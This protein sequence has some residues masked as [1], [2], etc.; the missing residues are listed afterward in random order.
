MAQR[1]DVLVSQI[2][3]LC[4]AAP[5]KPSAKG[6]D[7]GSA[8]SELHP[9]TDAAKITCR[10]EVQAEQHTDPSNQQVPGDAKPPSDASSNAVKSWYQVGAPYLEDSYVH[11]W[12]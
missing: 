6:H 3:H 5:I 11:H 12:R 7:S 10:R 9:I 8:K 1:R 4:V 2:E